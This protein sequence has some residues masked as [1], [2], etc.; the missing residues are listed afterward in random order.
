[1][2]LMLVPGERRRVTALDM[3]VRA[4]R[5]T[6]LPPV[7]LPTS[8]IDGVVAL[9]RVAAG[10]RREVV[11]AHG[12]EIPYLVGGEGEPV[13]FL[14]GMGDNKDTFVDVVRLLEGQHRVYLPDLGGF[15]ESPYRDD[16]CYDLG[17][18]TDVFAAWCD[19]VGLGCFHLVGNSLG[20]AVATSYVLRDPMRARS[21]MLVSSAGVAMP[22]PSLLEQRMEQG[23]NPFVVRTSADFDALMEL[24]AERQIPLPGALRRYLAD[25]CIARADMH[26]KIWEDLLE[27]EVDLTPDLDGITT[28]TLI[29]WGD[30]DRVLDLSAGRVFHEKIPGSR[31]VILHGVGHTPQ[32]EVPDQVAGI[33]D[34]FLA[35]QPAIT[36]P[37]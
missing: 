2:A 24:V 14:H 6:P 13:V 33:L 36:G 8:W 9:R 30:C 31:L 20:G 34:Q 26:A 18:L 21:L 27:D 29:L 5:S 32:H 1:M 22:I 3:M 37:H 4:V 15:G 25:D 17:S 7:G 10:L 12:F 28:P 35:S 11:S 16:F 19:A 23:L